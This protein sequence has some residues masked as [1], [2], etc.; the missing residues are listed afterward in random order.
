LVLT[1]SGAFAWI[2]EGLGDRIAFMAA[3]LYWINWVIDMALYPVLITG[4]IK[5]LSPVL[6]DSWVGGGMQV[7]L[8]LFVCLFVDSFCPSYLQEVQYF[9]P[10]LIILI[11]LA[12]N[13]IGVDLL[14]TKI[15]SEVFLLFFSFLSFN[16]FLLNV[17]IRSEY[18][19]GDFSCANDSLPHHPC[20]G[21]LGAQDQ[22]L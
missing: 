9:F 11:V 14:G 18:L 2:R 7:F 20:D 4:Y 8:C 10:L 16:L 21:G 13:L 15:R 5:T 3:H 6:R 17:L 22:S 12:M 19:F 1:L